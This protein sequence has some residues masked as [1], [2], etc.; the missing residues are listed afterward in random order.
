MGFIL[1][2]IIVTEPTHHSGSLLDHIW[3][4][5]NISVLSVLTVAT[6]YSGHAQVFNDI[7]Y[8]V[9]HC[10]CRSDFPS[11]EATP[12]ALEV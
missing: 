3:T 5:N 4:T 9:R 10:S 7:S 6:Y 1:Y 8:M 11:T 2:M 12:N